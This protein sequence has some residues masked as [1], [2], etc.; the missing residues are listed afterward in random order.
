[1][2]EDK[3]SDNRV[4]ANMTEL[5]GV[6]GL[7][8]HW[9]ETRCD[10]GSL[11]QEKKS[12]L[13][14]CEIID[15]LLAAKRGYMQLPVAA[16]RLRSALARH[17]ANFV[18]AYGRRH[19]KPKMHWLWDVA[20]QLNKFLLLLDALV[21][22]RIHLHVKKIAVSIKNTSVFERSVLSAVTTDHFKRLKSL[23]IGS[24]LC[25]PQEMLAPGVA[26]S[27][28]AQVFSLRIKIGDMVFR[29]SSLGYVVACIEMLGVVSILVDVLSE[30]RQLSQHS[31][32]ANER[33][34]AR[35][36]WEAKELQLPLAWYN[37]GGSCIVILE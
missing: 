9:V 37:A 23:R 12:F 33:V 28:A 30:V 1:M 3:D 8:R 17:I 15:I 10:Y 29:P 34:V 32:I 14:A 35:E 36:V 24:A 26:M 25:G 16:E 6:Y 4:K 27:N 20:D 2:R 11:E 5:L 22:E 31:L 13:S 21:I 7:I 19:V 18:S